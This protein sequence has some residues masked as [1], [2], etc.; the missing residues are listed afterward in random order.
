MALRMYVLVAL[1]GAAGCKDKGT[2]EKTQVAELHRHC[3]QLGMACGDKDKHVEKLVEECSTAATK[4][5]EKGCADKANA[6]YDCY[7]KEV[8]GSTTEKVWALDDL[9]VLATRHKKCDAERTA[10]TT[11][12]GAK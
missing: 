1:L 7:Q 9:R 11:C 3:E 2:P 10:L 8:C 4:Q 12:E 6:L 5:V